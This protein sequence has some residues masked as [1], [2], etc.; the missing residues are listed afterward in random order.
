MISLTGD[1]LQVQVL[2]EYGGKI[3][4][5]RVQGRELLAQAPDASAYAPA[6]GSVFDKHAAWGWDD[7]FPAMGGG[8]DSDHGF[9][10]TAP[11]RAKA[12][13]GGVTL[14]C[15]ISGWHYVKRLTLQGRSLRAAWN[16]T[17]QAPQ[18][19]SALWVC[20][21]L[22]NAGPGIRFLFPQDYDPILADQESADRTFEC[23]PDVSMCAKQWGARP[24]QE[25]RCGFVLPDGKGKVLI[26]YDADK[27]PFLGFWIITG[28]WN[29]THQFAFEPSTS[30]YDTRARA[31]KSGT[32]LWLQPGETA[33]FSMDLEFLS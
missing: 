22:W 26:R 10:W 14:T 16:I 20:H 3:T 12:D 25:G 8:S 13:Q 11:M 29:H 15:E 9:L 2:P 28:G 18:I 31:E 7:V 4:S 17:N 21:C 24:I 27:L 6:P 33:A 32:L 30:F 23:C 1:D 19:Q 5:L